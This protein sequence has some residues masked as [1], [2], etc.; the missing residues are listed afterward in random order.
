MYFIIIIIII[1]Q[2][3][4]SLS[5]HNWIT[6][7]VVSLIAT[8]ACECVSV[9]G[10]TIHK[11]IYFSAFLISAFGI[12]WCASMCYHIKLRINHLISTHFEW[13]TYTMVFVCPENAKNERSSFWFAYF[14]MLTNPL[15]DFTLFKKMNIFCDNPFWWV[16]ECISIERKWNKMREK[17]RMPT[18]NWRSEGFLR[19]LLP[20][21]VSC[22]TRNRENYL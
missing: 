4:P 5:S 15:D 10:A 21:V 17:I 16:S 1:N 13:R 14:L 18:T 20:Y 6:I 3:K 22:G 19:L 7:N 11:H 9:C 8:L 2:E 12:S